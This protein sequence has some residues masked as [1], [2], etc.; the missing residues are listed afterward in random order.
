MNEILYLYGFLPAGAAA[1]PPELRGVEDCPVEII[2]LEGFAAAVSRVPAADYAEGVL[3]ER[4]RDLRWMAHAGLLHER[5]VTWFVDHDGI[6][7]VRFLTLHRGRDSLRKESGRRGRVI[8]DLLVKLHGRREWDMKVT[9]D[10]EALMG[11]LG[12]EAPEVQELDRRI[13]QASPGRAYLL[14]RRRDTLA[15]ELVDGVA[16]RLA[17]GVIDGLREHADEVKVLPLARAEGKARVAAHAALLVNRNDEPRLEAH[18]E[19]RTGSLEARGFAIHFSGPWAP[20]RFVGEVQPE[21]ENGDT[22]D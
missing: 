15:R 8:R 13:D 10:Q 17:S 22:T 12:D 19:E 3:A 5:V 6:V 2:E 1:P 20:Y 16:S 14:Q 21:M 18:V 7:P 11:R 9:Y 4:V